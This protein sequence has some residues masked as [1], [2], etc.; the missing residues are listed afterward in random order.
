MR[1]PVNYTKRTEQY[2]RKSRYTLL[3]LTLKQREWEKKLTCNV[4]EYPLVSALAVNINNKLL[5][6]IV[7]D[8]LLL[9]NIDNRY[10]P[11][12]LT[13]LR[14]SNL[15]SALSTIYFI[16]IYIYPHQ[17]FSNVEKNTSSSHFI[18]HTIHRI[19]NLIF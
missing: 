16:Y 6:D 4:E 14:P 12:L 7:I 2:S 1:V 5:M 17:I 13:L 9:S 18:F 3:F 8:V 10:T 15:F 11:L 19:R